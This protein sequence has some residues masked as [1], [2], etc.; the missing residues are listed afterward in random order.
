MQEVTTLVL[1]IV[2]FTVAIAF[3]GVKY[4]FAAMA[5]R[6]ARDLR[7]AEK[8]AYRDDPDGLHASVHDRDE[9]RRDRSVTKPE[10]NL[11]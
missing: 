2:V 11:E 8:Y 3:F 5:L 9:I 6:S 1:V 10:T 7:D 4:L